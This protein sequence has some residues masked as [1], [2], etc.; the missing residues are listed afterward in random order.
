MPLCVA[1]LLFSYSNQVITQTHRT[2]FDNAANKCAQK[3]KH[4]LGKEFQKCVVDALTLQYITN[5]QQAFPIGNHSYQP[6]TTLQGQ[7]IKELLRNFTCDFDDGGTKPIR[8]ESWEYQVSDPCQTVGD[9]PPQTW[10]YKNGYLPVDNDLPELRGE[11]TEQ[12]AKRVCLED[13][14]CRGMTYQAQSR[15]AEGGKAMFHFK[16]AVGRVTESDD[17]QTIKRAFEDCRTKKSSGQPPPIRL[18]VDVLSDSPPI[19]VVHDFVTEE[20]CDYMMNLTIP[21]MGPSIVFGGMGKGGTS[22]FRQSFSCNMYP[23][24]DDPT[25]IITKMVRRKFAFAREVAEYEDLIE[26]EG[27][28]PLNAVFYKDYDDQYRSHCDGECHGGPWRTGRRIAT[29]LTYC[30]TADKGGY[31]TF[32]RAGIK[33]VPKKGQMLFFGYKL[34]GKPTMDAGMTEHSGCPLREGKKWVATMWFREGMTKQKGWD[35]YGT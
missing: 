24:F 31:T 10:F 30:Q 12:E 27:Q 33:V 14:R 35:Q 21:N 22:S 16:S 32:D 8:S 26:N 11:Y 28:E 25:N 19:F 2:Q 13:T 5:K 9:S 34:N 7:P 3:L 15:L 29:S 18:R 17:W 20:E 6:L 23:D 4:A 1:P